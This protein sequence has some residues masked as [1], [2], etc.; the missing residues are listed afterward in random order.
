MS[1]KKFT[2]GLE[3]LFGIAHEDELQDQSPLLVRTD[4]KEDVAVA[5]KE[6][7][8]RKVRRR[9]SKSFTSDL[10]SL[11]QLSV[12]DPSPEK[13]VKKQ[14][15]NLRSS[16]R[17]RR[18]R[19][20]PVSGLDALIRQ[21]LHSSRVEVEASTKKRVTFIFDKNKLGKLKNIARSERAYLKDIIGEI[22][23]E[24]IQNY[25][26]KHGSIPDVQFKG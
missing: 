15:E 11:F 12:K 24:F 17:S 18:I 26:T 9:S 6:K 14:E 2:D 16:V 23:S 13:S 7:K 8:K 20:K 1:K 5:T 10:E 22:I 3:N 25:E 4:T 21:T 19:R